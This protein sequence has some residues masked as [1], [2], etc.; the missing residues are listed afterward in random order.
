MD[1]RWG[2]TQEDTSDAGLGA[3]EHC[4]RIAEDCKPFCIVLMGERY[5]W[6]PPSYRVSNE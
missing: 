3:L 4:L 2:L 1:L 5:G 6:I